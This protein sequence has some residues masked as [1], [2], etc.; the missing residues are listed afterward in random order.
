MEVTSSTPG[1][2]IQMFPTYE[3]P[4]FNY[5]RTR[6]TVTKSKNESD[7][8]LKDLETMFE[9]TIYLITNTDSFKNYSEVRIGTKIILN[10]YPQPLHIEFK[11]ISFMTGQMIMNRLGKLFQSGDSGE[12]KKI[13]IVYSL[14]GRNLS[15]EN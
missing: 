5:I 9:K 14:L 6:L 8:I 4:K 13:D 12:I 11:K 1:F 7:D 15:L 10:N 3:H 2:D